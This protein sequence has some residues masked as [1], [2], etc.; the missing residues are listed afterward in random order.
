MGEQAKPAA[1]NRCQNCGTC[2]QGEFC[3]LCGQ[4]M[5]DPIRHAGHALEEFFEA[6]W[7][8]D[9]RVFRT[10]RDLPWPGRVACNY[11]A[12][13]RQR[14]IAPLR[15]FVVLSVLTFF[16]GQLTVHVDGNLSVGG[17]EAITA[18]AASQSVE[19]VER[20]RDR[21][22]AELGQARGKT[23]SAAGVDGALIAAQ[24]QVRGE[25]GNRIAELRQA[26]QAAGPPPDRPAGTDIKPVA[27]ITSFAAT[28][29]RVATD[30]DTGPVPSRKLFSGDTD[31]W[32]LESDPVAIGWLPDS[33][34]G[35]LNHK[36]EQGRDNIKRMD[37]RVDLWLAA[38]M[39]SLP[40]ALFV[41]VPVF[42]LMLKL[43]Y[44]FRRRLYLEHLVVALY[45]H[46]FLL[47]TLSLVFLLA[48][49]Q[50]WMAPT[51]VWLADGAGWTVVALL[52]W[53][54]VYLLLMQKRV[55]GQGWPMTTL[56][57]LVIGL[58]YFCLLTL[59]ATTMFLAT[60]VHG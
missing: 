32:D 34:N 18:I 12:G 28:H 53:M 27:D 25:A 19:E 6:L 30:A 37:G 43:A 7:H 55:Y 40:S 17:S 49:L 41:L 24:V 9:G 47:A 29:A 60:L 33:V 4:S 54:P 14:Y 36:L 52:L 58:V 39:G 5:H 16:I 56:K 2:L 8:L 23:R 20:Q 22:L 48:A 35:W 21:I 3:H 26:A 13:H 50:R 15:L 1:P 46:A 45:S 42:A 11:L 51:V 44:L 31:A 38:F 10:F 59:A 57:Y